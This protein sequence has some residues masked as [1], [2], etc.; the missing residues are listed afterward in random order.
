MLEGHLSRADEAHEHRDRDGVR[1]LPGAEDHGQDRRGEHGRHV[2]AGDVH[3]G[4]AEQE[5]EGGAQPQRPGQ[6]QVHGRAEHGARAHERD[7]AGAVDVPGLARLDP[8]AAEDGGRLGEE[9]LRAAERARGGDHRHHEHS[10]EQ[11]GQPAST[12]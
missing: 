2:R 4:R 6:K 9:D 1:P 11:D 8:R 5:A 7:H 12:K 10:C 3:E